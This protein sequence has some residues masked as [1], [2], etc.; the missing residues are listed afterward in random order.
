MPRVVFSNL[1][2]NALLESIAESD[3]KN[4]AIS[5][6]Q[7]YFL[8]YFAMSKFLFACNLSLTAERRLSG[9]ERPAFDRMSQGLVAVLL[10]LKKKPVVRVFGASRLCMELG[11]EMSSKFS[12]EGSLFD[13]WKP[14][15]PPLLLIL[16]R[17]ED[18]VTPLLTQWTYQAM[19]HDLI[20]IEGGIVKLQPE[21]SG[22]GAAPSTPAPSSTAASVQSDLLLSEDADPFYGDN[23][24]KNWGDL[25]EAAKS[26]VDA[27]ASA[28]KHHKEI[29]TIEDMKR[30]VSSLPDFQKMS[31]NISKHVRVLDQLRIVIEKRNLYEVSEF[32]Q[33][34]ACENN[35]PEALQQLT[36]LLDPGST[37]VQ[38]QDALKLLMLYCLRY[39]S[40]GRN[41]AAALLAQLQQRG[42]SS[43]EASTV[44]ALLDYAGASVRSS[45]E[46][47]FG[48][49]STFKSLMRGAVRGV[50]GVE[51][52]YT[53][54]KPLLVDILD[55]VQKG[56]LSLQ[57]YPYLVGQPPNDPKVTC[58]FSDLCPVLPR[59]PNS[60]P[61]MYLEK[62][63]V[64]SRCD[65]FHCRRSHIRRISMRC[66]SESGESWCI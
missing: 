16:D 15:I 44:Q 51:N 66:S 49:K 7:E 65:R 45:E 63:S 19:I 28:G 27:V 62:D 1:L 35:H 3:S 43:E 2:S 6:V 52:V 25:N 10:S 22:V 24:Y 9:S 56:T 40:V 32:E 12:S 23:M 33:K 5:T 55:R 41:Q 39:E 11:Q 36:A 59:D 13:F 58:G 4:E 8:D 47:L 14:A 54:H 57:T 37:K 38:L 18:P 61:F 64:S 17:R 48:T 53:Q 20:G 30:I 50:K 26:S 31:G 46:D 29:N 42:L 21:G 60:L 34:L